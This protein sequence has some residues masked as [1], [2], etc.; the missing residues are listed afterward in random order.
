MEVIKTTR[1]TEGSCNACNSKDET[2]FSVTLKTMSFRLCEKCL[3][4]LIVRLQ[5]VAK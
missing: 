5:K 1:E 4:A 3:R 2:V